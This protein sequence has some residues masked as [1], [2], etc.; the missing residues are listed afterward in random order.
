M[1]RIATTGLI[2]CA[3][4]FGTI[5]C[6]QGADTTDSVDQA[7]ERNEEQ[8]EDTAM[9]E[10]KDEQ[11]EFLTEAASGGMMEVELGKLAQQRATNPQVKEF[12][13]MMVKDHT[14]AN[15]ELRSLATSK[16]VMLPDSMSSDHMD[17]VRELRDKKGADFDKS[18]MNLMVEDHEE[19]VKLFE[20]AANNLEDAEVKAFAS[21][22]LTT[23]R[24]HRERAEKING[25]LK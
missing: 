23:L 20:D 14:A 22:T 12:A 16:N 1:K 10:T 6:N 4:L 24:Q 19:D 2:G 11:S 3:F 18:Y 13:G 15:K 25:A 17:H 8:F 5:A 7:Q 9:E 21:K